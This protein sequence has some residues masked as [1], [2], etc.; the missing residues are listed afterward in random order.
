MTIAAATQWVPS[1]MDADADAEANPDADINAYVDDNADDD[2][3]PAP[4]SLL[5]SFTPPRAVAAFLWSAVRHVVPREMLGGARSRSALRGFLLRL[6]VLRRSYHRA[7]HKPTIAPCVPCTNPTPPEL[8]RTL[9]P[10][11]YS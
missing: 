10:E 2:G 3:T 9:H 8:E 4:R 7:L 6:V 5:A 11:Y 1:A